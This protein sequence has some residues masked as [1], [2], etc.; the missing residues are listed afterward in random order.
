MEKKSSKENPFE[1]FV[2]DSNDDIGYFDKDKTDLTLP[3]SKELPLGE[4]NDQQLLEQ[5]EN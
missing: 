3:T 1:A 5:I 4:C 2:C